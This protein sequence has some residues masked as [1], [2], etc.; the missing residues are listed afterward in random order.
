[1][2]S[3]IHIGDEIRKL[4]NAQKRSINWLA[5]EIGYDRTNLSRKLNKQHLDAKLMIDISKGLNTDLFALYS[6]TFFVDN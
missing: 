2:Q 6:Q 4:L 1:M 3:N 5:E